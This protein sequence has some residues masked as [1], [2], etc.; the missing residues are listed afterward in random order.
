M[1]TN[2]YNNDY[3]YDVETYFNLFSMVVISADGKQ[4][5][6]FEV[7]DRKDNREALFSFLDTLKANGSRLVGFNNLAFDY[8]I[9]H[10]IMKKRKFTPNQVYD[11]AQRLFDMMKESRF[12]SSIHQRFHH[13]QQVDLFKINHFD[14]KAKSTSLKILQFNMRMDN[15]QELPYDPSTKLTDEQME[16]IVM[17]NINDVI[18]TMK[19]YHECYG[20]IELRKN[21]SETY[22]ID[23]TNMNDTKIGSEI[24]IQEIEKAK[25]NSCYKI[26]PN[27]KREMNQT[28][29]GFIDL[30]EVILPYVKFDRPEFT[31]IF[32]WLRSQVIS[33][34]KG[35]FSNI[36]ESD[37]GDV[38]QYAELVTK[39]SKKMDEYPSDEEIEEFRK[40]IPF[41][42]VETN[43]LKSGKKSYFF[44]W[45]VAESLNVVINGHKYVF[46]VGG[47]HSSIDSGVVKSNDKYVV[48][49][50]DV[51]SY[52]PNLSIKNDLFPEHLGIQFCQT[53]EALYEKRKTYVKG[54]PE[55]LSIKLALN[56]TYGKSNDKYSP[57][58]DPKYTMGITI[59]GQL[60]LCMLVEKILELSDS[61]SVQSNTDGITMKIRR[62]DS[63][64]ADQL[65][66]E[67]EKITQLEM[68]RND[69]SK[70]F[71]RDVNNYAAIYESNGKIKTKGAYEYKL[72]HHKDNS[73]V[74]V[75]K[76]VEE[77]L[78]KGTPVLEYITNYKDKYDF[79]L[80]TKIPKSFELVSVDDD[81]N[82]REEQNVTRYYVSISDKA[83][84]LVKKMPPAKGKETDR[85]SGIC[86]GRKVIVCNHIEDFEWDIDYNYYVEEANKLIEAFID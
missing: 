84:R 41:A 5:W 68:E 42:E 66:K 47:I 80:R 7:S 10:F 23:F 73:S 24:F 25:P 54:S 39:K 21:L 49:D 67:W 63:K 9:I 29:R 35:V 26:L 55:N 83:R 62:E 53:Y 40:E 72:E 59:N 34:T 74:V 70:M 78:S 28:K 77:F 38:A 22:G 37:L 57:F 16:E 32:E 14:N 12:G 45:K 3:I 76:A 51:A 61:T 4:G 81:G 19:F 27:G 75:K 82:E 13:I 15:L 60:S 69:Y 46:G 85:E 64:K 1:S 8:P 56:G 33:E 6:V 20:A 31:A 17:Y 65:V 11:E 44:T 52:Y 71:V 30:G 48:V 2:Y 36:L 86:V 58:Y 43:E 50:W 18:A 79:M